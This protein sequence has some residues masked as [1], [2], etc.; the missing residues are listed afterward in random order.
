MPHLPN[1]ITSNPFTTFGVNPT[2]IS[3]E[4]EEP[5]E[6]IVLLLRPS[7]VTLIPPVLVAIFLIF[8]PFIAAVLFSVFSVDLS[9]ILSSAQVFLILFGWYLFVFGYA[10]FQF[11]IWY[12]NVYLVTNERIV[13]FDFKGLLNR[14]VAF[15][16]LSHIEDVTPKTIGF[17]GTFFN[18]GNVM[19]QTA[20]K[21]QEFD[22]EK[23]PRPDAVA[24]AILE[25][26]NIEENEGDGS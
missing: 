24:E 15:A 22:F 23:V 13:D 12:F 6:K 11:L 3:F 19:I 20:G 25:E 26:I 4:S 7:L 14:Q 16:Q 1:I 17:F 5:G 18:Y 8:V 9:S 21:S 10:F 2:G